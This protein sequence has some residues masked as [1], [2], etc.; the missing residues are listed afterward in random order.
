MTV[1]AHLGQW[2]VTWP[3]GAHQQVCKASPFWALSQF[4]HQHV[5]VL[6]HSVGPRSDERLS[7][8]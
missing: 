8:I 3:L 6:N 7:V 4:G 5:H 2:A 1:W